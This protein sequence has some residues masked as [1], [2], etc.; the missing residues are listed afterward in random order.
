MH[1][2]L[3]GVKNGFMGTVDIRA[4]CGSPVAKEFGWDGIVGAEGWNKTELRSAVGQG[5]A[6][7]TPN[8]AEKGVTISFE[9]MVS[10]KLFDNEEDDDTSK[11]RSK[12]ARYELRFQMKI[13]DAD[14]YT[15]LQALWRK[16]Q[17]IDS[18]MQASWQELL[19]PPKGD[20][21]TAESSVST[22]KV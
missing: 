7:V 16:N 10:F 4:E 21:K 20:K 18:Q 2:G 8:G 15:K 5:A 13:A 1:M 11:K 9:S 12:K 22:E 14:H 19:D 17:N 3:A 6:V